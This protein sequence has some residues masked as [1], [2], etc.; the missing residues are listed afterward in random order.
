M[1]LSLTKGADNVTLCCTCRCS[2]PLNSSYH[3]VVHDTMEETFLSSCISWILLVSTT[4]RYHCYIL[5]NSYLKKWT[6]IIVVA[7]SESQKGHCFVLL[8]TLSPCLDVLYSPTTSV[9]T[10]FNIRQRPTFQFSIPHHRSHRL[11]SHYPFLIKRRL[12]LLWKIC[13]Q[14][15][16][17]M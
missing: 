4:V 5:G 10:T 17:T 13:L 2:Q 12:E 3:T 11:P 16:R 14:A 6:T 7:V 8:S 15:W 9:R 1:T